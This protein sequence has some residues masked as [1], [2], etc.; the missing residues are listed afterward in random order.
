[1]IYGKSLAKVGSEH[2]AVFLTV[3]GQTCS[4]KQ[5][6]DL[7]RLELKELR[8]LQSD[9]AEAIDS[10]IAVRTLPTNLPT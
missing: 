10:L 5:G 8:E 4:I 2:G 1:M 7:I 3:S 6:G 9:I